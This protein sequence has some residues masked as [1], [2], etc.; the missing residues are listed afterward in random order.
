MHLPP[1]W[2]LAALARIELEVDDDVKEILTIHSIRYACE[3]AKFETIL[4]HPIQTMASL[5]NMI[6]NIPSDCQQ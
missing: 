3:L 6:P 4:H 1:S 5:R 2:A